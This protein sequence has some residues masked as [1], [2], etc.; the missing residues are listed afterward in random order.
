MLENGTSIFINNTLVITLVHGL[1]CN[2][3]VA[4]SYYGTTNVVNDLEKMCS[5]SSSV[6]I[7]DKPSIMRTNGLV[8]KLFNN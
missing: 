7:L 5:S 1:T 2:T 8:T 3:V 6:V 4:H